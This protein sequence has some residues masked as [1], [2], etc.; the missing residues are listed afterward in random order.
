MQPELLSIPWI[1]ESG[2]LADCVRIPEIVLPLL[3]S[4]KPVMHIVTQH[5][6]L[7]L[8]E[9]EQKLFTLKWKIMKWIRFHQRP[10]RDHCARL[11]QPVWTGTFFDNSGQ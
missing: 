4:Q 11:P 10:L 9:L 1:A 5:I 7:R 2:Q 6:S 8:T 3:H